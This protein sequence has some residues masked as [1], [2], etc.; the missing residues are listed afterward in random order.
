MKKKIMLLWLLFGLI[1]QTSMAQSRQIS[2][3]VIASE[4]NTA[5]PGV[6]IAVKGTSLGTVTDLDGKFTLSIPAD[7]QILVFSYIGFLK[8]EVPI[9]VSNTM[10]VALNKDVQL[11]DEVVVTALGIT[12]EKKA[13]G[14]SVQQVNGED[15][16]SARQTNV[17]DAMNGKVAGA[18]ITKSSGAAGASSNITL[19]GAKSINGN[20]SPLIVIDGIP[21]DNSQLSSGNP[22]DAQN[23]FLQSVG[24][25]NRSIDI[26]Q[27]DIESVSVLKGAAATALYGSLAGNGAI[28]ITTKKGRMVDGRKGVKVT[29]TTGIDRSS[30]NK[31]VPLQDKYAQGLSGEYFGPESGLSYSWGPRIDTMGYNP[32]IPNKFDK[33][34]KV[35]SLNDL[36]GGYTNPMVPYDN[37][38]DFYRK[39]Y[40][41]N[42]AVTFS[43]ATEKATY[44]LSLGRVNED[45]IIPNNTFKK[46]N[47]SLNGD[48]NL[49]SKFKV[50]SSLKYINSGGTRIEQGSNTSGVMLGLL[51]T[52][53]SFDNSNGFGSD[54]V[55]NPEAYIFSNGKQRNYRGGGG[56]DNPFWTVNQN[57]LEDRVDR[58]IG[59]VFFNYSFYEWLTASY[60]IGTD[61]YTDR[62]KQY[63][64][65]GSRTVPGGRQTENNYFSNKFN[66]DLIVRASQK[67][68]DEKI[69]LALTLGSN[70]RSNFLQQVYVQGDGFTIPEFYH[71]SNTNSQLTRES[72]E[73]S[74]DRAFYGM[75]EVDYKGLVYLTLTG[76]QEKSS[77]LPIKNNTFF[78]PSASVA[79]LVGD[80]FNLNDDKYLTF[81][82][83][84]LSYAKV[85]LGSPY[86]YA[87]SNYWTQSIFTDGW[88][89]TPFSFP[90][91]GVAGFEQF[92]YLGNPNLKPESNT[93][94]ELGFDLRFFQNRLGLDISYYKSK[95]KDLIFPVPIAASTGYRFAYLNSGVMTNEGLEV[96]VNANVVKTSKVKWDILVNYA[97]NRNKV[98][99]LAEGVDN[100]F[101]GGFEGA[102]IRAEA[103]ATYGSIYGFGFYRDGSGALVIGADG[104]PV[105]DP[106][107]RGFGSAQPKYTMGIT[108][109]VSYANFTF[110]FLFDIRRGGVMWNGTKGALYFFGTHKD[111]ESRGETKT[112]EG[113]L[114]TFDSEGNIV[115][116]GN[117]NPVTS[118]ANGKQVVLDENWLAFGNGNGFFGNNTED[119]IEKTDWLRLR[120]ISLT[121]SLPQKLVDKTP[122]EFIDFTI[123]GRNWWLKTPYT[124]VDPETSLAGS[125]NEQGMDYFNMPNTKSTG[126]SLRLGF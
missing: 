2:G 118:G 19:R 39:A 104:F 62:R 45:G 94:F 88:I 14:Y 68:F 52:P 15:I 60:K 111:T 21:V 12:R 27:E 40:S 125:R 106:N 6:S 75:L 29:F 53:A 31:M 38:G 58:I 70:R 3:T 8:R 92:D 86:L 113:N 64:A 73:R 36:A 1:V 48:I 108:N 123:T 28:I 90:F 116:D 54:A 115:L 37:I 43:G 84:R 109:S 93:Q 80:A 25:S 71:I 122:F 5:L 63:F 79:F 78:Y 110:S 95:S 26:P 74:R 30:Y 126:I 100:V 55:D 4:D 120:Q 96:M 69:G 81:S 16:T 18:V 42:T 77:T 121:Y 13:V 59:N 76:R 98:E 105:I 17:L 56:Y 72:V 35:G 102:N 10:N 33:K 11:M 22:D 103:G 65:I 91:N 119:F 20:N 107:E 7:A 47:I 41:T 9:G 101:L 49:T 83:I 85:G 61:F 117:G 99:S 89:N 46:T 23:S 57:P 97:R 114:A 32:N 24:N 82:K 87:T 44:F 51:R 34:G 50:G 66:E 67:V 112:F 124:G